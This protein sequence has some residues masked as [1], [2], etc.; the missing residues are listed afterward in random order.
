MTKDRA[1]V[2]LTWVPYIQAVAD[3]KK[4]QCRSD[5]TCPWGDVTDLEASIQHC[6]TECTPFG[7]PNRWRIKPEPREFCIRIE[8]SGLKC[9]WAHHPGD[10]VELST[11]PSIQIIHVREVLDE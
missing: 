6:R 7:D 9:F 2:L 11:D 5:I 1:K 8:S 4:V 10:A 3:G